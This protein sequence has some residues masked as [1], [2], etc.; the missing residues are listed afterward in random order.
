MR[1]LP[2]WPA[3]VVLL[4]L[5]PL[6]SAQ[7]ENGSYFLHA[8]GSAVRLIDGEKLG[9]EERRAA[10]FCTSYVSGFLDGSTITVGVTE[11]KPPYCYPP[12]GIPNGQ[13]VRIFVKFLREN[14]GDLN[15]S[16]RILLMT[17]L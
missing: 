12:K 2:V 15:Q 17:S 3:I 16:G 13:V 5:S 14:P 4:G 7:Q 6:A 11:A 10:A 1:Q 9:P 8:C